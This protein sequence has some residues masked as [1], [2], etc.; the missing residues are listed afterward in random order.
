M[1]GATGTVTAGGVA[2]VYRSTG[3]G[4]A[5]LCVQGVGVAGSGWDPQVAALA[6]RYR[7]LTFDPDTGAMKFRPPLREAVVAGTEL[8]FDDPVCRM[9]LAS[10]DAMDLELAL[11]RFGN[12]TVNF[13]EDV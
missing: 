6:S 11:R 3:R 9:R 12:P 8:N 4:P 13:L 5:V 1:T 10:D 7:V 2:I